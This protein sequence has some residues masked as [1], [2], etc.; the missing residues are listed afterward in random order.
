MLALPTGFEA[1]DRTTVLGD[2]AAPTPLRHLQEREDLCMAKRTLW[3]VCALDSGE[4]D[5]TAAVFD[6]LWK[7][8]GATG[9]RRLSVRR[10]GDAYWALIYKGDVSGVPASAVP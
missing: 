10:Q 3:A 8:V 2:T 5:S 7:G 4:L 6:V 1:C 9:R